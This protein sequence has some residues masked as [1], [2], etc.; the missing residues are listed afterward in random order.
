MD[1]RC[2]VTNYSQVQELL[3]ALNYLKYVSSFLHLS[4]ISLFL[5]LSHTSLY[6]S[7]LCPLSPSY[8][9]MQGSEVVFRIRM[10]SCGCEINQTKKNDQ[11]LVGMYPHLLSSP[12][13]SIFSPSHYSLHNYVILTL[14][15]FMYHHIHMILLLDISLISHIS[16]Y[17][18]IDLF[19]RC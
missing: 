3:A 18:I 4:S 13:S 7:S 19:I 9:H 10:E 14:Q 15:P 8:F 1:A 6:P 5:P 11:F 2:T 17:C 16:Y 12:H